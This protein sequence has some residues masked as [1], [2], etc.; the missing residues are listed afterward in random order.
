MYFY[1][2]IDWTGEITVPVDYEAISFCTSTYIYASKEGKFVVLDLDGHEIIL[3]KFDELYRYSEGLIGARSNNKIGFIDGLGKEVIPFIY[4]AQ[5]GEEY[6]FHDGLACVAKEEKDCVCYGYINHANEEIFSFKYGFFSPMID[7]TC[8]NLTHESM[9][10]GYTNDEYLLIANGEMKLI[11][12]EFI[13]TSEDYIESEDDYYE[14][15]DDDKMDAYE[16]DYDALW[17]TD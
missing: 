15:N 1:G 13:N 8:I 11:D 9:I 12:T 5:E 3:L 7:G 14:K 4:D 6:Y 2:V 16:G 10:D 17:N